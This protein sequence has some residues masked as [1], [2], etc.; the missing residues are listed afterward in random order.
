[1]KPIGS[2]PQLLCGSEGKRLDRD[3]LNRNGFDN[4]FIDGVPVSLSGLVA[5]L[6]SRVAPLADGTASGELKYQNFS[7]I[8]DNQRDFALLTAT[9]IDGDS[10]M[11]V[12]RK[13][14]QVGDAKGETWYKDRRISDQY[15]L[16]QAFY[17]E[18]SHKFDR[19]H[20][21]RRNDPT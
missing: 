14:G 20:L 13:T 21:T 7:V 1:M 16:G 15:Y 3:Y 19:G 2:L 12:N 9:N 18:W 11:V 17:S 10:Y 5:P 6:T 4:G 8:M